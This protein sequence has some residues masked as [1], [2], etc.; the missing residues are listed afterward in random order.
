VAV[1]KQRKR[2]RIIAP[3]LAGLAL[4]TAACGGGDEGTAAP[5]GAEGG[6]T[7]ALKLIAFKPERLSV[8]AGTAV[9]WKNEDASE[10]TV[11]SGTVNQGSGGVTTA[12]DN[13]FESGSLKQNASFAYTFTAPGTYSYFCKIH[14]ATMRGEITVK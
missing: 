7:V 4:V 10:H 8:P 1:S 12:V 13:K 11:T 5:A 2:S 3:A 9:S 14:P 6:Q